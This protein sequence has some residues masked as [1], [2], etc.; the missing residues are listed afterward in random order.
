MTGINLDMGAYRGPSDRIH[1]RTQREAG[2][3]R[4]AWEKRLRPLLSW[5]QIGER[6][7][8]AV[9]AGFA[10]AALVFQVLALIGGSP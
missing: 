5:A 1:P 8:A 10:L 2:V 6:I 7:A 9:I 4:F 3:D